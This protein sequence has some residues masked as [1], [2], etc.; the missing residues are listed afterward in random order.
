MTFFTNHPQSTGKTLIAFAGIWKWCLH[1]I[2]ILCFF[3]IS[4][5]KCCRNNSRRN[6]E[7]LKEIKQD[8]HSL[9]WSI[10]RP[11]PIINPCVLYV[12]AKAKK[13]K[14][15]ILFRLWRFLQTLQTARRNFEECFATSM[16]EITRYLYSTM[17]RI[18]QVSSMNQ[19][20]KTGR[21]MR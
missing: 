14:E 2:I 17:L 1:V 15:S 9:S 8:V 4:S 6:L 16:S 5:L 21:K 7:E 20:M 18:F 19:L 3:F 13:R 11:E 12:H 10:D